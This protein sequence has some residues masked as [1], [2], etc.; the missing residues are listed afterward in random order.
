MALYTM[1]PGPEFSKEQW[2][3]KKQNLGLDFPNLPYFIDGDFS[4]TETLP[5]HKYIA[6]KWKPEL[7]GK[8]PQTRAAISMLSS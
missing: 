2:L 3:S 5:I 6:D 7:K 4:L 1:G 8:D